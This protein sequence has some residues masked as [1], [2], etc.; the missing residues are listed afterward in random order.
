MGYTTEFS[1]QISVNP[2]LNAKEIAFLEKFSR[3]RRMDRKNGPYF[4]DGT[5]DFGQGDDPDI[6]D[7]NRPPQG[8]PSLWC[9]WVPTDD[10]T[11][12]EWDGG[13]K[14]YAGAEW[15]KYLIQHFIG[16]RPLAAVAL[17]F[18]Q[19]HTCNGEITA[20]GEDPDDRWM[21]IVKDSVV[22]VALAQRVTYGEPTEV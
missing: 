3:S 11:A 4:V 12:I 5:G 14:F 19:G 20:Q 8:Q 17:S 22:S 13:E 2:P 15:M 16:P 21:L 10:G 6:R 9:Q 18:L 1:G 7:Y